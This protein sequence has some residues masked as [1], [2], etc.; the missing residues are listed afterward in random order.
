[1][2]RVY[3]Y[4]GHTQATPT[5]VA[6]QVEIPWTLAGSSVRLDIK[7]VRF[8]YTVTLSNRVTGQSVSLT[9]D[10]AA[11]TGADSGRPWGIPC[12]LFPSTAAGGVRVTR[13][14]YVADYPFPAGST[15]RVVCI[16]DSITEASQIGPDYDEGWAYLLEDERAEQGARDTIIAARGGQ[17]S[18]GAAAAVAEIVRL[19]GP[20]TVVVI[21]IGT[22]DAGIASGSRASWRANVQS[23][24][25]QLRTRTQRIALCML[26]PGP[27]SAATK[28]S[29]INEDILNGYFPGLLPPVRFDLALSLDNDG[30]TWNPAYRVDATHP[31]VAGNAVMLE[32]LRLDC[33]EALE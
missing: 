9:L 26:P 17:K 25:D 31:N 20:D 33:P 7:R 14:R 19:C 13:A 3:Q 8:A 15:A 18:D 16:G 12:I 29:Q 28:R 32:R 6:D 10:Y 30:V 27:A 24:L 1:M 11:G 22:N 5:T 2:L 21:L 23:M 4:D